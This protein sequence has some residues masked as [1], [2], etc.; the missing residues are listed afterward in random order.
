MAGRVGTFPSVRIFEDKGPPFNYKHADSTRY[1]Q[2]DHADHDESSCR[3]MI[4]RDTTR[5][6]AWYP[7]GYNGTIL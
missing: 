2:A 5:D 7:S 6:H 1:N 4:L 3:S